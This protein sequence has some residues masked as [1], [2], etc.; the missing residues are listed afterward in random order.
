[1]AGDHHHGSSPDY[2]TS[3]KLPN[4]SKYHWYGAKLMGACMWFWIMYRA[5]QDLPYL[6]TK[7]KPWHERN[8]GHH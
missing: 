5:K 7:H 8:H 6:I 2:Y 3:L 4:I 1:M